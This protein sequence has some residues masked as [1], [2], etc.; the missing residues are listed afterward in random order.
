VAQGA[1]G[2]ARRC[3]IPPSRDRGPGPAAQ[4]LRVGPAAMPAP[5]LARG[6]AA[7]LSPVAP[8]RRDRAVTQ[9]TSPRPWRPRRSR[10]QAAT[11]RPGHCHHAAQAA[12]H[13]AE[14]TL[15]AGPTPSS[16]SGKRAVS[17]RA[18]TLPLPGR[19][20]SL[21]AA[22]MARRGPG[23]A[24]PLHRGAHSLQPASWPGHSPRHG[25]AVRTAEPCG[26]LGRRDVA[27]Q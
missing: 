23:P 13:G 18:A 20:A 17:D 9:V 8:Q 7:S 24:C 1:P 6:S 10:D 21:C 16:V 11:R 19:F 27:S 22:G 25:M 4:P 3:H 12:S 15:R 5:G 2:L 26:R 14:P